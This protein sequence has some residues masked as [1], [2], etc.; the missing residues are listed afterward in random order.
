[1][2]PFYSRSDAYVPVF[3]QCSRCPNPKPM[4]IFTDVVDRTRKQIEKAL[5]LEVNR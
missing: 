2:I 5:M 4:I 1:M 3:R